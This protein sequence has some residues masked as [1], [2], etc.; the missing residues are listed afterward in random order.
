MPIIMHFILYS[1]IFPNSIN[2]YLIIYFIDFNPHFN[3]LF[4]TY[5][6]I[7]SILK[8]LHD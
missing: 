3:T 2:L 6:N 7:H 5:F 4:N 1:V 8:Y